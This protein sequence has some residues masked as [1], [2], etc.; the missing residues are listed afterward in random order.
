MSLPA[1]IKETTSRTWIYSQIDIYKYT[2]TYNIILPP[3][4][5]IVLFYFIYL[6]S[7]YLAILSLFVIII[8]LFV[9]SKLILALLLCHRLLRFNITSIN[10][11]AYYC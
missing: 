4:P 3:S 7:F 6:L 9:V 8:I 11:L 1:T 2:C 5:F 10:L